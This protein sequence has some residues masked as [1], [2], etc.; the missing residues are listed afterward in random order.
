MFHGLHLT[1]CEEHLYHI[2]CC[3][4]RRNTDLITSIIILTKEDVKFHLNIKFTMEIEHKKLVSFLDVQLTKK[5]QPPTNH[6]SYE[7][8]PE[9]QITPPLCH[10]PSVHKN[11]GHMITKSG[12][13]GQPEIENVYI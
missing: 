10:T 1:L 6:L 7:P 11:S 5:K 4:N 12:R 13:R 2:N 8:L 3:T 9:S